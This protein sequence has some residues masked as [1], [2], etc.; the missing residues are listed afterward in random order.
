MS[1]DHV[2]REE[3]GILDSEEDGITF[4]SEAEARATYAKYPNPHEGIYRR[5]ITDWEPDP[6]QT[7]PPL[8]AT[9]DSEVR[10]GYVYFQAPGTPVAHTETD[11]E[12]TA[13]I[14]YDH[15]GDIVGI[16]LLL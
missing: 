5:Y 9:W 2:F 4:E 16:E 13:N 10:A 15:Q 8:T 7:P 3:W 11:I 14:D 6:G 12:M 1:T